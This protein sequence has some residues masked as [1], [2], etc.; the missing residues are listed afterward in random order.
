MLA[1]G[2]KFELEPCEHQ[3]FIA[4]RVA[5]IVAYGETL[6]FIGE[7]SPQVLTAWQLETPVAAF[8]ID[9]G[10]LKKLVEKNHKI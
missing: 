3:T 5:S 2:L 1:L 6:G 8:E 9:A 10:M 4:G 7:I